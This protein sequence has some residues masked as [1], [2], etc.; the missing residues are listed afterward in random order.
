MENKVTVI[1]PNY[2]N[3]QLL[4]NL[5][6]SL[7]DAQHKYPFSILIVDDNSQDD[8]VEFIKENYPDI[9]LIANTQN[10]GFAYTVN[11]GI[12]NTTSEFIYLLNN[13]TTVNEDFLIEALKTLN[14]ENNI[15][16]V[17]S[18]MLQMNNPGFIDD[19]GDEYTI[20]GWSKKRG[21]GKPI[22]KYAH[23]SEVFSAC[24]GAALY[25]RDIFDEIGYFDENFGSYVED[26]DLSFRAKLHGY[27]IYYSANSIVNHYGSAATGSRYNAFKVEISARNNI[28]MIYKN[29]NIFMLVLNFI[30]ICLGII[31][32]YL[33][34]HHKGFEK[35]Y[36]SGIRKAMKSRGNLKKTENI[37]AKNYLKVEFE[38]IK[39]TLTYIF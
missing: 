39:N 18:K 3:R 15:F 32:K 37:K 8:S 35:Q 24:A 33:F 28:Y 26:M 19:A 16:A 25:R 7:D 34:F 10:H 9:E 30:F 27:K 13:D 22:I 6:K 31:I 5:L 2:N 23:D 14:S 38:M 4:E 11:C 36:I 12:R 17:S 29:M 1:I 20:M 21:D